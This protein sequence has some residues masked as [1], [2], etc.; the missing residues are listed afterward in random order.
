MLEN[1]HI[2]S[3]LV[4]KPAMESIR[5]SFWFS[6][7]TFEPTWLNGKHIHS[8]SKGKIINPTKNM[9]DA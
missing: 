6:L 3:E 7:E 4:R 2:T 5:T 1:L 8:A 9:S